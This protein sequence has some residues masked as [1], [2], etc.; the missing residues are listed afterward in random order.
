MASKLG[1]GVGVAGVAF[2]SAGLI[3]K[4]SFNKNILKKGLEIREG[5]LRDKKTG[6]VFTG[7]IK[8]NTGLIIGFNKV[9]TRS[10]ENGVITEKTYKNIL[11]R[12]IEGVFYKDGKE[13][14]DVFVKT[15]GAD[16]QKRMIAACWR[17]KNDNVID[18]D[19]Y[20]KGS[21]F[22]WARNL[23]KEVGW[24]DSNK[25]KEAVARWKNS[26]P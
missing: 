7:K 2:V 19:I 10:F 4:S 18:L 23:V 24:F 5:L 1:Y 21:A 25:F 26:K 11:G 22:D 14:L 20:R 15:K 9:E 3:S 6:D 12:E 17:D 16:S 8:S 13:C